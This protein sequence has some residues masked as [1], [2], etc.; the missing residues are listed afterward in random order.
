MAGS[1]ACWTT[2]PAPTACCP[3]GP[4]RNV[5]EACEAP[6]PAAQRDG[7]R[8]PLHAACGLVRRRLTHGGSPDCPVG[9]LISDWAAAIAFPM[10]VAVTG[11]FEIA[12]LLLVRAQST[13]EIRCALMPRSARRGVADQLADECR[14]S[15]DGGYA[16][17]SARC[18]IPLYKIKAARKRAAPARPRPAGDLRPASA[19][20]AGHVEGR[21]DQ[22]TSGLRP[23]PRPSSEI[24]SGS[25]RRAPQGL[26]AFPDGA[27]VVRPVGRSTL[28]PSGKAGR[29]D[30]CPTR[31][32]FTPT[33]HAKSPVPRA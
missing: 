31:R 27:K 9:H 30:D 1:S 13:R 20:P 5:G 10:L 7:L 17:L 8:L 2:F 6:P 33:A 21:H 15:V 26:P 24:S 18:R 14:T 29:S 3:R 11:L 22:K 4:K 12:V 19:G 25:P 32:S 16:A 28:S 23:E